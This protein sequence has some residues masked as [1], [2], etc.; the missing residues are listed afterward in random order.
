MYPTSGVEEN[1]PRF[2]SVG[3]PKPIEAPFGDKTVKGAL[4]LG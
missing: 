4:D 3:T 1:E 2:I